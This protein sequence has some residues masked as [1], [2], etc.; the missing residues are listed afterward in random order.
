L[1]QVESE[2]LARGGRLVLIETSDTSA[3]ASA[4]R[5]YETGGYRCEATIRDFY[6]PGDSLL[7]FAKGLTS[8]GLMRD[9]L[10]VHHQTGMDLVPA[11]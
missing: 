11:A 5:L 4:R 9:I 2:V 6:A 8:A 3:Y 1:A 10:G 7:L